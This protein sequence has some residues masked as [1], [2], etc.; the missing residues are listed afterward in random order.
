MT[1][2]LTAYVTTIAVVGG[3]LLAFGFAWSGPVDIWAIVFWGAICLTAE[4]L[5]LR[6]MH[7]Q[8]TW[9]MTPTFHLAM[10]ILITP[11]HF[12]PVIFV[13]RAIG[14]LVFRRSPW[15]K[16]LFNGAQFTISA[17]G[18]WSVYT[19]LKG[20]AGGLETLHDIGIVAA[21][22]CM[23]LTH[24]VLNTF[25]VSLAV[26]LDQKQSILSAWRTNFGYKSEAASSATQFVMAVL[27]ASLYNF[28]GHAAAVLFLVPLLAI[29]LADMRYIELQKTHQALVR[30]AR[31]A[32]K[33]EMAAEV[34]HEANNYL[35]SLSGRAQLLM[36]GLARGNTDKIEEHIQVILDQAERLA[37]LTKGLVEFSHKG[38]KP[39]PTDIGALIER[40]VQFLR[41]QNRFDNVTMDLDLDRSIP[42]TMLDPGQIQQVLMNLLT[43]AADALKE[44]PPDRV[45]S[46]TITTR[47][48]Q[49]NRQLQIEVRDTGPGIPEDLRERVFEPT[50]TTKESGHGFG[51]S[52]SYRI[53]ENHGGHVTV[54]NDDESGAVFT[55]T[56][57]VKKPR[58]LAQAA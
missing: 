9:A 26:A 3:A 52:T 24:F 39:I 5:W 13:T 8:A 35:A 45:K 22:S 51:L 18:A 30:S 36:M 1:L 6:T 32:A 34:A 55:I 40:T 47:H 56:L 11:A 49:S 14:D 12:Q 15:Y 4:A 33:G 37:V 21:L 17:T 42:Q 50:F 43:N 23:G 16:A 25:L 38:M 57:P 41:P 46:I 27:L 20:T 31:M 53:V 28:V 10:A 2:K 58:K 7:G 19:L 44:N 29:R 54:D 48:L